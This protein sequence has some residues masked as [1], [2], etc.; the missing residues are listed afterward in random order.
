MIDDRY[1]RDE[2]RLPWLETI[3]AD[4]YDERPSI[5]RYVALVLVGLAVLSV[6]AFGVLRLRSHEGSGTGQ[7]IPAPATPYKTRPEE[8]GGLKVEGEGDAAIATSDGKAAG[9][10][11]IDLTAVPETPVDTSRAPSATPTPDAA[12]RNTVAQVPAARGRLVAA[13]PITAARPAGNGAVGSGALVQ[14]GAYPSE[15]GAGAAWTR[16]TKRFGYL[17]AM[18][19][20]VQPVA[21]E[22]KTLYRLRV[23]AGSA[24]AAADLCGRLRVA[25]EDCFLASS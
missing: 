9:T 17:A 6:V 19:K 11:A 3:R 18:E 5:M 15:A 2:D 16:F 24:A 22:G 20:V 21:R 4:E 25:G 10:G 8:P 14:L 7:L 13:A 23:N 1:R 12:A